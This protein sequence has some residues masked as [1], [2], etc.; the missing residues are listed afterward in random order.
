[1]SSSESRRRPRVL[2]VRLS[3]AELAMATANAAAAGQTL[4]AFVRAMATKGRPGRSRSSQA[5]AELAKLTGALGKVGSNVNQLAH[6]ANAG[7]FPSAPRI[8]DALNDLR[9]L[10]EQIAEAIEAL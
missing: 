10:R 5:V 4:A 2:R 7:R 3:D 9:E 8:D 1:M 6:E